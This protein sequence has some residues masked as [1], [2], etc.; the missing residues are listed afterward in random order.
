LP[1]AAEWVREIRARLAG[2]PRRNTPSVRQLRREY[3]R[4]LREA[5]AHLVLAVAE[6]LYRKPGAEQFFAF[7]LLQH[8]DASRKLGKTKLETLGSKM[9]SWSA[10]DTFSIYLAGPTWQAGRVGNGVILSWAKSRNRWWRRAA[11]VSTVPLN[12]KSHGGSGDARR[13]LR[14]CRLLESDRD[15][16]VV[17]AL[18]WALRVLAKIDPKAVSSFLRERGD[19]LAP[20]VRREVRNKLATGRKN[21]LPPSAR[22]K[23]AIAA[24]AAGRK[25]R[26][27]S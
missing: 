25:T 22:R 21:P 15:P 12:S 7:E 17:K 26:S 11:L 1:A 10:V 19:R 2:L 24:S 6:R 20:L 13:T 23:K 4:R 8:H 14:V 18:S 16:M 27:H 5:P 9:D 3:S